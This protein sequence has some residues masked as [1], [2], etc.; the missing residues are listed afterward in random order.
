MGKWDVVSLNIQTFHLD[1]KTLSNNRH[2]KRTVLQSK[3]KTWY[4]EGHV[5][6]IKR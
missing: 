1:G 3:Q 4:L 6:K 5:L 2:L